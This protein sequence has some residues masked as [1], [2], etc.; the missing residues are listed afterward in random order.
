[1]S[2]NI[3][4]D[5]KKTI[6]TSID[7]AD[8][9]G[10]KYLNN[11][12]SRQILII[13]FIIILFFSLISFLFYN[14][15]SKI[16]VLQSETIGLF[17]DYEKILPSPN[18][19]TNNTLRETYVLYLFIE[20]N[21]GSGM[22][23]ENFSN[24]KTILRR[25]DDN[26]EIQYNPKKNCI[27]INFN[28]GI[29]RFSNE[30]SSGEELQMFEKGEYVELCDLPY[31]KWFQLVVMINNRNV[32][33]FVNKVL[34]KTQLLTNVPKLSNEPIVLGKPN[35]NPNLFLGRLEYIPNLINIT[36]IQAL[37]FKNMN[38]LKI[39]KL[40]RDKINHEAYM[41]IHTLGPSI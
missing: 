25:Q 21:S 30:P 24:Y 20:N 27:G 8:E 16:Q 35:F 29:M 34:R 18:I 13:F 28:I 2:K 7:V 1:M 19:N 32:D 6:D 39:D 15:I 36:E 31:Q 38:F 5:T 3:V 40:L 22:F 10:K 17:N 33:I 9:L 23:F 14:T 26:F 4:N 11:N 41:K 12:I 37:Y